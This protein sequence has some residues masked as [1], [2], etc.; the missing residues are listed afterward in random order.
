MIEVYLTVIC[1]VKKTMRQWQ[2]CLHICVD[3]KFNF[4]EVRK[5]NRNFEIV[6][7]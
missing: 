4:F 1:D 2:F 6:K 3:R 7:I 5:L